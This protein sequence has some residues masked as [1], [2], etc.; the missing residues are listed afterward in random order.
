VRFKNV[1]ELVRKL[2]ALPRRYP[3]RALAIVLVLGPVIWFAARYAWAEHHYRAAERDLAN[4]NCAAAIKHLLLC[5]RVWPD[6]IHTHFLL[7]RTARRCNAFDDAREHLDTCERL[8]ASGEAFTLEAVL[9]RVQQG[10]MVGVETMLRQRADSDSAESAFV[11]EAL[12]QGYLRTY[13]FDRALD[14]IDRLLQR[15]PDHVL[16]LLWHGQMM[17]HINRR[18]EAAD[19][20][21]R[22]LQIN[23][24]ESSA[25][26]SLGDLLL[27]LKRHAESMEQFE[28]LS[29]RRPDDPVVRLG[30][31]CCQR[32]LGRNDEAK[33][34]LDELYRQY[35]DEGRVLYERGKLALDDGE[36]ERAEDLLRRAQARNPFSEEMTYAL[37]QCL[38]GLQK[39]DE[40]QRLRVR[41]DQI[42]KDRQRLVQLT[43]IVVEH[44]RAPAERA[45][46]GTLCLRLGMTDH[47]LSLLNTAL[48]ED[49]GNLQ[50]AQGLV[51][52]YDR[53]REPAHADLYRRRVQEIKTNR[54]N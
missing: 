21:R 10:D 46:A 3:F 36:F 1:I 28:Y 39:K 9:Q 7:A 47:A 11:L 30:I 17:E 26:L 20:Y 14:C 49:P 38:M 50:A 44:R 45:E 12:A 34:L 54:R 31:A 5:L 27:K 41:L 42:S 53:I 25:R 24:E 33:R 4:Q 40:A 23:P 29:R 15:Q 13:R 18:D 16:A 32:G 51:E 22:V 8:G 37:Y 52:Y 48:Q 2:V 35:P 6:D 19:D 43:K